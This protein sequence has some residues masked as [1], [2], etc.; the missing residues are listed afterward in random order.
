MQHSNST[1]PW[2][3]GFVVFIGVIGVSTG[4]ILVRLA[5]ATAEI[6]S[7]GF[8]LVMSAS[9][10]TFAALLLVPTW[11][12]I[13]W[14]SLEPGAL[15]YAAIAGVCL[16]LHFATWITSLS[17]TS[18]AAST[19]LV[20]TSPIWVAILSA[21]W[22]KEKPSKLTILGI[23]IALT[24]GI[25]IALGDGNTTDA[26]QNPTL[27]NSL[28]L[29][30]AWAISFYLIFGREAQQ[31][32]FKIGGYVAVAYT[33][34]ALILLPLPFFFGT[35]Y[36]GYPNL[37][38]VYLILMAILPQLVG[39]T[40]FSWAVNRTSPTL[41]MLAILFEPVGASGLG[42]VFFEEIPSVAVLGGAIVILTGVAVAV[43]GTKSNSI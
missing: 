25:I 3:V 7:V 12:K 26:S 22:L 41:V 40:S 8:S 2:L 16:A 39:H 42:Y 36:S 6:N 21:I 1:S 33:V 27:G 18:I 38:Y 34:A 35:N 23:I 31:R 14:R 28:A 17:Y 29:I 13:T 19:T 32:G 43:L 5:T 15:F 11:R 24:G 10:L 37:V 20:T 4:A 30:G 9:R